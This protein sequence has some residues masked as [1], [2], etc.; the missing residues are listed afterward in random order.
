MDT[1]TVKYVDAAGNEVE[2]STV[3]SFRVTDTIINMKESGSLETVHTVY[4][5]PRMIVKVSK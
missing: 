1:D 3:Q 5:L 4:A 2:F